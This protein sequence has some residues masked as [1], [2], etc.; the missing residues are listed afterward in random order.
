M[1]ESWTNMWHLK[2]QRNPE[3]SSIENNKRGLVQEGGYSPTLTLFSG[4]SN[5]SSFLAIWNVKQHN[6]TTTV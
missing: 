1:K 2:T 3:H 5:G 6:H 4:Y